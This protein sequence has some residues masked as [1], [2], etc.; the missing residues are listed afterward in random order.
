MVKLETNP[1]RAR[2]KSLLDPYK[3]Y[4]L[5]CWNGGCRTDMRLYEKIQRQGYRG[6]RSTVL[7]YLTQLRKAQ[8][9][10][11]RTR[12]VQLAPPVTD[13]HTSPAAHTTTPA[14]PSPH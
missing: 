7:G 11:P 9:L 14:P 13:L 8:G 5:D 1:V 6:G 4:L 3:P 12:T 10:A 2:P